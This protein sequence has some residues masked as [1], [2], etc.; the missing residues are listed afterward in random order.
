MHF[1]NTGDRRLPVHLMG[2]P[3]TDIE[4]NT[5]GA[6][7]G[8]ATVVR[9]AFMILEVILNAADPPTLTEIIRVTGLP[10]STVYRLLTL[11]SAERLVRRSGYRYGPGEASSRLTTARRLPAAL[12]H[13]L[14]PY[15]VRLHHLTGHPSF[16][17][18]A[19]LDD[20]TVAEVVFDP[21]QGQMAPPRGTRLP[22]HVTA[23]GKA[24][25]AYD[26]GFADQVLSGG[27]LVALTRHTIVD[28]VILVARLH[29]V[30]VSGL[31]VADGE[32]IV[33]VHEQAVV[34]QGGTRPVAGLTI[35]RVGPFPAD[36]LLTRT[37]RHVAHQASLAI[38]R[39]PAG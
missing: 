20:V 16:L 8:G 22:A 25:M 17:C 1:V 33:G 21:G 12:R 13:A 37:V 11:L 18:V 3:M 2:N 39:I 27:P 36:P 4:P 38:R 31:A 23:G 28:P 10:K 35:A 7:R 19:T 6:E 9:R 26:S 24:L 14:L 5:G 30:R 29:Q 15:V 34:I 32:R